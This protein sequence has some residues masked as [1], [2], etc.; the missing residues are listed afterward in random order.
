MTCTE[1]CMNAEMENC[2][3]FVLHLFCF[4]RHVSEL[5]NPDNDRFPYTSLLQKVWRTDLTAKASDKLMFTEKHMQHLQNV[6]DAAYNSLR[7]KLGE[8]ALQ[9]VTKPFCGDCPDLC[10]EEF[11]DENKEETD[12]LDKDNH[13]N[14]MEQ[15]APDDRDNFDK[16]PALIPAKMQNFSFK[17]QRHKGKEG[18]GCDDDLNVATGALAGPGVAWCWLGC[19][20]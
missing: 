10:K 12:G 11:V 2:A 6:Q 14:L 5:Q 17:F 8:D 19:H 9:R 13:N 4:Y 15:M 7:C 1:N 3:Q 16:D 18:C 20:A